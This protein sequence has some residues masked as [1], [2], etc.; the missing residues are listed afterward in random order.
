MQKETERPAE[1]S[2][3]NWEL[4]NSLSPKDRDE[5]YRYLWAGH[6]RE[7]VRARAEEILEPALAEDEVD[8]AAYLYVYEGEYD[9][10]LSYW[11]NID[12]LIYRQTTTLL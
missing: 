3:K 6:V 8:R 9:C 2:E 10:N 4:V 7:D 1:L 11:D 12:N 5:V